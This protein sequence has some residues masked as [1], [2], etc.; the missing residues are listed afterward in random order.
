MFKS[1]FTAILTAAFTLAAAASTFAQQPTPLLTKRSEE[2]LVAVVK[3]DAPQKDKADACRELAVVGTKEAVT[4]LAA[5]LADE[6][7]NHIARYAL[8]TIPDPS[9]DEAFRSA[10]DRL[11]SRPLVGVIGSVGV[12]RDAKATK[13][14]AALLTHADPDVAQAA[15]RALGKIGTAD[16]AKAITTALSGVAEANQ[17]AF[18]EGLFRCAEALAAKG[19]RMVALETYMGVMARA[20]KGPHQVRA[21]ALR[22]IV[23]VN[24]QASLPLLVQAIRGNDWIE[25]AAA[26]RTAMEMPGK[27]VTEAIAGELGKGSADKQILVTLVLGKRGDAAALPAL[28]AAAKK[29]E[30]NVRLAAIRTLPEIGSASSAPLLVD[31]LGDTDAKIAQTAQESLAALP[32][33]EVDAAVMAML[34]SDNSDRRVT[35][36]DLMARRR[37]TTAV[38]TLVKAASG[39]D[40]KVR[41]A[42][43]RR[44]GELAGPADLP[45]L[46]DLLTSAKSSQDLDAAE[47]ALSAICSKA[48]DPDACSEKLIGLLPKVP[49]AQKSTVLRILS[50]IGGATALKATRAAVDDP[51]PEVH[52]AAIRALGSWKTADAAPDLLTL[53]RNANNPTDRLLCLR[54]YLGLA[55]QS[56]LPPAQRLAMCQQAAGL[57]KTSQEKKML[58]G[59]LGGIT[60]TDS[61]AVIVPYLDDSAVRDEASTAALGIAERLLQGRN[62]AKA[63][64]QLVAPLQKVAQATQ[65]ADLA[66][67]AKDLLQQ[68]QS[69]GGRR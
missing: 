15:A 22:G 48:A 63:A 46:L 18:C 35:A 21:C 17:L 38:P 4:A 66:K 16:A 53:A 51:D 50:A 67:R 42:A 30:Q 12:R 40:A 47:Q 52:A 62:T 13:A 19:E 31:L 49:S 29:G 2:Q 43:L 56:E 1:R 57:L 23:L 5:M 10:L 24:P 39:T 27:E 65:N 64:P 32:G 55:A 34:D 9:V 14:L 54:S 68:A 44:L 61:L 20:A 58:L 41:P 45:T 6:K 28:S 11:N 3:S 69:R 7:L 37:M 36:I 8:E 33:K 60:T 59:T 26:A 25:I